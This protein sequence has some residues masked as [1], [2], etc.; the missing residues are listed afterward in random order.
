MFLPLKV[1]FAKIERPEIMQAGPA[2]VVSAEILVVP[3]IESKD[4]LVDVSN[5]SGKL[6]YQ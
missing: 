4:L 6:S 3:V 5:G 1:I 2:R